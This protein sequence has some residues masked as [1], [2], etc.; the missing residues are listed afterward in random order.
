VIQQAPGE[1]ATKSAKVTLAPPLS[2]NVGALANVCKV[3]E[4]ATDT[5]PA[6]SIVGQAQAVTPLLPVPLS[7]PVRVVENP[8]NLPKLVVYLN[9]LIN[10]RLTGDIQL[11]STGTTTTFAAIPDVPLSRFQLDFV[12]GPNGLVGT[13]ANLCTST[14]RIGGDFTS[15]SGKTASLK[16]V[17][18]VKG[19]RLTPHGS[20]SL[21]RLR[22]RSPL[23]SVSVKRGADGRK[24]RTLK[25]TLPP[26][27]S[28]RGHRVFRVTKKKGAAQ[29]ATVVTHGKLHVSRALRREVRRHPKLAVKLRVTDV[30]GKVFTLHKRVTAR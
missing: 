11:E 7:G 1:A 23:L 27:L 21:R 29:I 2:P 14:I 4:Y 6:K 25:V 8:G 15:Q 3:D 12:G 30:T 9:G 18:A 17:A 28:V 10:L 19:C 26:G 5:C 16:A 22:T 13:N 24:L 20:V